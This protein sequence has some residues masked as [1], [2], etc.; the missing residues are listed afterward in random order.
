MNLF[1]KNILVVGCVVCGTHIGFAQSK[2][3]E[4]VEV[5]IP[6]YQAVPELT[7]DPDKDREIALVRMRE[8]QHFQ[9]LLTKMYDGLGA[10]SQAAKTY[11]TTTSVPK[12]TYTGA[13][14][15]DFKAFK[16]AFKAWQQTH[17]AEIPAIMQ[18]IA[19]LNK[20]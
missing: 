19:D 14:E 18:R 8:E 20:H 10:T 7:G 1:I 12:M 15:V 5:A 16:Q 4:L 17:Q 9:L 6:T 3:A 11:V 13:A 2:T